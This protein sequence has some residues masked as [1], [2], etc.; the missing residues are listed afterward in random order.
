MALALLH[1]D[2]AIDKGNGHPGPDCKLVGALFSEFEI[3]GEIHA[4][5]CNIQ[6]INLQDKKWELYT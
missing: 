1:V 4:Y 3:F 6:K 2:H 5:F